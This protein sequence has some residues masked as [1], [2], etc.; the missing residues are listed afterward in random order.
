MSALATLSAGSSYKA[1]S[2]GIRWGLG[3]SSGLVLIAAL[4]IYLK[5]ELDLKSI[6]RWGDFFVGIFML[7]IGVY[8]AISAVRTHQSHRLRRQKVHSHYDTDDE[9]ALLAVCDNK[10]AFPTSSFDAAFPSSSSSSS[11]AGVVCGRFCAAIS[12][13]E[14]KDPTSQRI[15]AFIIGIVHGIAGPGAILGVLPAVEMQS[16][17]SSFIYLSSFIVTSTLCMGVFAALYGE[18]SKRLSATAETA[19]LIVGLFS[20][21]L[22]VCVGALWITLS[23]TGSMHLFFADE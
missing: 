13:F 7:A 1:F 8:S 11:Q 21:L 19:E 2:V 9:C 3:H 14:L 5:G 6:G 17:K 12:Q 23:A 10:S 16:Y 22:S 20:A 15:L 18:V 4:F